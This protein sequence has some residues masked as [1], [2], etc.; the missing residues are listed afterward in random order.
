[1]NGSTS[2]TGRIAART[3]RGRR[4]RMRSRSL[5]TPWPGARPRRRRER[6]SAY[7]RHRAA[8]GPDRGQA[9]RRHRRRQAPARRLSRSRSTTRGPAT[10][11]AGTTSAAGWML[12]FANQ[13][14]VRSGRTAVFAADGGIVLT[15]LRRWRESP[16]RLLGPSF[17]ADAWRGVSAG[18]QETKSQ[19]DESAPNMISLKYGNSH[20]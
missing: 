13:I 11:R 6:V 19:T 20:V 12:T 17:G 2:R 5:G 4:R 18:E 14:V 10:G 9:Q 3:T 8:K 15:L 16:S 1:L 7:L